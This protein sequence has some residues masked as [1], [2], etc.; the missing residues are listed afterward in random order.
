MYVWVYKYLDLKTQEYLF[1]DTEEM[2]IIKIKLNIILHCCL[3]T[4]I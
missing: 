1:I 2:N 3:L 4:T